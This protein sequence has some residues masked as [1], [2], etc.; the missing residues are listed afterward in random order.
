MILA[1]DGSAT[2]DLGCWHKEYSPAVSFSH[3][4]GLYIKGEIVSR[5]GEDLFSACTSGKT[6]TPTAPSVSDLDSDSNSHWLAGDCGLSPFE[7]VD[8][9]DDMV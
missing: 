7:T 5:A 8:Q 3:Q 1:E 6:V 2:G 4:E 9:S